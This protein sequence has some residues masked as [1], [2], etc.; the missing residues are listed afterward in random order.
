MSLDYNEVF[1]FMKDF[2]IDY[3]NR[4]NELIID[5]TTNTYVG[6][7]YCNNIDDVKTY[8]VFALCRPIGKVLEDKPAKRLLNRFNNYFGTELTREDMLLMYGELCYESK[9]GEF[10]DFIKRGFPMSELKN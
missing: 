4:Y 7:R 9:L 10:R 8:V 6:I 1:Q 2:G 3:I 5:E